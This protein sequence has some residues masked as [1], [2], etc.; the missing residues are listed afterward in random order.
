MT[1]GKRFCIHYYDKRLVTGSSLS[2]EIRFYTYNY[3]GRQI[4]LV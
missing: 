4:N 3:K 2:K 1:V